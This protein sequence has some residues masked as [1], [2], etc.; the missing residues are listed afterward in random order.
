LENNIV[1]KFILEVLVLWALIHLA[2]RFLGTTGYVLVG[3]GFFIYLLLSKSKDKPDWKKSY[4]RP[5]QVRY[6]TKNDGACDFWRIIDDQGLEHAADQVESTAH[7][8]TETLMVSGV[9]KGNVVI[10][11]SEF[12]ITNNVAHFR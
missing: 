4:T 8:K 1:N 11:A 7:M 3:L 10:W 5:Y 12:Y 2:G 9:L 6:N